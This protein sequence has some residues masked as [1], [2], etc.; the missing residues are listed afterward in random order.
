MDTI[1]QLKQVDASY[2]V[3]QSEALEKLMND[4]NFKKVILE[5]Y[6]KD[7]AVDGV[8]L[9]ASDYAKNSGKRTD[10]MEGLI[11]ISSLEDH[12]IT[13]KNLGMAVKQDELDEAEADEE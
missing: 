11:A 13:I 9:L 1:N 5:G 8:S 6:L 12:F 10:I 2:W 4:P 3:E 7:K